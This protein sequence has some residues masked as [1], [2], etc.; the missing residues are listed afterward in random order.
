MP[1]MQRTAA[2]MF[3]RKEMAKRLHVGFNVG[4]NLVVNEAIHIKYSFN[5]DTVHGDHV[6]LHESFCT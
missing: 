5:I 1:F 4:M 2:D 3:R 6:E